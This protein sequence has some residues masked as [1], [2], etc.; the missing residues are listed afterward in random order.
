MAFVV[1]HVERWP[2]NGEEVRYRPAVLEDLCDKK[3]TCSAVSLVKDKNLTF[4][5]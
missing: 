2:V 1:S 3:C 5:S 4:P